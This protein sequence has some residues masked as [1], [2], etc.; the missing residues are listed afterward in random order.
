MPLIVPASSYDGVTTQLMPNV[1][2]LPTK[3]STEGRL[4][5]RLIASDYHAKKVAILTQD[6]DYGPNVAAGFAQAAAQ[7]KLDAR[8]VRFSYDKPDFAAAANQALQNAPDVVYL[9]GVADDMGPILKALR[10][11]GFTGRYVASEGFFDAATITRF[12]SYAEGL[13]ASASMPPLHLAPAAE[14][15]ESDFRTRYGALT[16]LSAFAYAAAQIIIAAVGRG[17]PN[18]VAIAQTIANGSFDTL[19]GNFRFGYDGE[20]ADPNLYFYTV[21]KG[22]W[23]YLKAAHPTSFVIK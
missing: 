20:P 8:I 14:Q 11:A 2:R 4:A 7:E 18:R 15:T 6:G 19:V 16:P 12:G 23:V 10:D 22:E 21:R 3:D 17:S 13:V 1:F 9:A 5:A